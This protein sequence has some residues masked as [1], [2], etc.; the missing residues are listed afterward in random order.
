MRFIISIQ[1][2]V[3]LFIYVKNIIYN[4]SFYGKKKKKNDSNV[5]FMKICFV[6]MIN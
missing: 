6:Y 1:I 4:I 2:H 5:V 3:Y